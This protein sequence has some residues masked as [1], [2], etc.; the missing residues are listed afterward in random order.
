MRLE[1]LLNE[2]V[3]FQIVV[4]DIESKMHELYRVLKKNGFQMTDDALEKSLDSMFKDK[5]IGFIGEVHPK[6]LKNWK[7]KMPVALFE[8]SLDEIFDQLQ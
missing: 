1:N 5:N 8:I 3:E 4:K 7:I 6:I 2:A